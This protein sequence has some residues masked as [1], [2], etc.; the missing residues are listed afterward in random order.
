ML[1]QRESPLQ[2]ESQRCALEHATWRTGAK[3]WRERSPRLSS[4]F[5]CPASGP[6]LGEKR[7]KL[8]RFR[9]LIDPRGHSSGG[10]WLM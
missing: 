6:A 7:G 1:V 10:H 4:R 8:S 3:P 5:T 2:R 9:L